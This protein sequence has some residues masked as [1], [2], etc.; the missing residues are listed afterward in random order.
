MKA[1]WNLQKSE[2]LRFW[3]PTWRQV[4][5]KIEAEIDVIFE[6]RFFEKTLF[7][8]SKNTTFQ[9]RSYR[10]SLPNLV[11]NAFEKD[12]ARKSNFGSILGRF[13]EVAIFRS[14]AFEGTH[15]VIGNQVRSKTSVGKATNEQKSRYLA[16]P[17]RIERERGIMRRMTSV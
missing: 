12:I 17:L 2:N 9:V 15:L 4:G 14:G 3:R 13:S 11:E 10:K 16:P 8:L 7:F 5:T 6:R 1:S